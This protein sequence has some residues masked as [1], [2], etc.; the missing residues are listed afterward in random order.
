VN[1]RIPRR[2]GLA[3][4]AAGVVLAGSPLFIAASAA[5]SGAAT[6]TGS[7]EPKYAATQFNPVVELR[8]FSSTLERAN[9]TD[10]L[11]YELLLRTIGLQNTA[12]SVAIQLHD[13]A[14]VYPDLCG[15]GMD[16]CAG[17]V[18][19]YNWQTKHY[20]IV[21]PFLF[22]ARDGATISGHVWATRNGPAQRPGVVITDGS[23]QADEQMYWYAAQAL[24]KDG[25][26]VM[27]FDPQ[28]QGQSD[29]LG[30]GTDSLEGFPAQT[31]GR[32]FYDGTE[33]A[34]DFFLSTPQR[35]Y[36]PVASCNSGTSHA[37]KQTQRVKAGFDA[38]YNPFWS[39][40]NRHQLGI[41]GHSYGA[42]GVSYIAQWDKR[43]KAVVAWDNLGPPTVH[44]SEKGCVDAADRRDAKIRV[45]GLGMSADYGLPPTPNLS[46]PNP[47]AKS[48]ESLAYSKHHVDSGEIIIR[49]GSHLD[50]SYIP[51]DAFGASLRGPDIVAWYTAAWFDYYV[52]GEKSGYRR[53]V[54]TRWQHDRVEKAI[55]PFHDG[56]ALSF[57][58]RSRLD[59]H[60][61]NGTRFD[62][63]SLRRG[64]R[65]MTGHDGVHGSYSYLKVDTSRDKK[66]THPVPHGSGLYLPAAGG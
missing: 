47:V 51:N 12:A 23:V 24:A 26:V 25:Y 10:S 21:R 64:C 40:L 58:Y 3:L 52:K 13:P 46:L 31:D 48:K 36:R 18:R 56:N 63:E 29:E 30:E 57:Y 28:G 9:V 27:T 2:R 7:G 37:V 22:T 16:G 33:D 49:G 61:P 8:N 38:A 6:S 32:P 62:C 42:E 14:R 1:P 50:F 53:L 19:L 35:P 5:A 41:A 17:D 11:H 15:N 20:G 43:V 45:P 39:I 44:G 55:D 54:T 65:G 4:A 60:R 59:I 66:A 34:I